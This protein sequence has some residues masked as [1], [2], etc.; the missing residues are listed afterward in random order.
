MVDF[1]F[2][3]RNLRW[4]DAVKTAEARGD[5]GPLVALLRAEE[6]QLPQ[7]IRNLLADLL[8]R[9][10]LRPK[11]GGQPTLLF[12]LSAEQKYSFA[13]DHVDAVMK[14]RD[15]FMIAKNICKGRKKIPIDEQFFN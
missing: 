4:F 11:R 1:W 6:V 15:I 9:R 10:V 8:E 12:E 2:Y 14:D 3:L 7:G 5:T 13:S